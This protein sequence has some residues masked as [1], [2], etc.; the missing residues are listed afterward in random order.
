MTPAKTGDVQE[1][2]IPGPIKK[3]IGNGKSVGSKKGQFQKGK[4]GN[5]A[6]KPK[7][8]RD[9]ATLLA[10]VIREVEQTVKNKCD[11]KPACATFRFHF[12]RLGF[13]NPKVAIALSNKLWPNLQHESTDRPP[14]EIKIYL[15]HRDNAA[16]QVFQ[17]LL[18][19]HANPV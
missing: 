14:A 7:G 16:V 8:T 13:E 6:G 11:H 19:P 5:P 18:R 9:A 1:S 2:V 3:R 15:G 17:P 4:S 10:D 12:V